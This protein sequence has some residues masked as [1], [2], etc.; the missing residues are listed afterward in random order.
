MDNGVMD[1]HRVRALSITKMATPMKA[2][3]KITSALVAVN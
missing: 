2:N 1:L 3:G